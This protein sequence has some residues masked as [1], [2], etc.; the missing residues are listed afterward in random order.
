MVYKKEMK[1]KI[2][3][4]MPRIY[5]EPEVY[6]RMKDI[7]DSWID[8]FIQYVVRA[9]TEENR[10]KLDVGHVDTAFTNYRIGTFWRQEE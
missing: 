2:K 9:Y 3:K 5:I 8:Y 6:D 10:K 1:D 7:T 4:E